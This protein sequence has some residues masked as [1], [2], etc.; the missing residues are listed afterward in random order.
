MVQGKAF[1]VLPTVLA[2]WLVWG[3]LA[4]WP[5]ANCQGGEPGKPDRGYAYYHYEIPEKPWSIHV[6]KVDLSHPELEFHTTCGHGEKFGMT[7]VPEQIS[8]LSKAM[9]TP[10][11]AVNGDFYNK[12]RRY[13]GRPR[14]MQIRQGELV[15]GPGEHLCFWIDTNGRP[16]MTNVVSQFRAIWASGVSLPFNLND[17]R[18]GDAAVLY[19]AALGRSTQTRDGGLE[20]V[21]ECANT[22]GAWLPLAAGMTYPARVREV[23][24]AGNTPL[25]TNVM[26]LS[27]GSSLVSKMPAVHVGE[28]LQISTETLPCLAGVKTAIGGGPTLLRD[29]KPMPWTGLQPRHPRTALGWN[30]QYLFMVEVDG[31]QRSLSVG[32]TFPELADYLAQLG[33]EQAINLDGGGSSTMW[34]SGNVMNSPSEGQERPAPN[35]LV[36][37]NKN[38]HHK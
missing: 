15:S 6:F 5:P 17:D 32:M 33:C 28:T 34:V 4:G 3:A 25:N 36:V 35:A 24:R 13:P 18:D 2:G 37:I 11:A 29:G 10:L 20:L 8:S 38:G 1:R 23:R 14:D 7:T 30:K 31:R 26:V 22:N 9:G 21:L 19:T 27:V 12:S 16:Q